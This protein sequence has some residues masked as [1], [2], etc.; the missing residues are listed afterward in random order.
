MKLCTVV[1]LL[2]AVSCKGE[3]SQPAGQGGE[4]PASQS[5]DLPEVLY[6]TGDARPKALDYHDGML[7]WGQS[8]PEEGLKIMMAKA[9]GTSKPREIGEAS[10]FDI[11]LR[12]I[13]ASDTHVFWQNAGKI[14]S[15]NIEDGGTEQHE[16]GVSAGGPTLATDAG[17]AV[18]ASPSCLHVAVLNVETGE[19]I[20]EEVPGEYY[21]GTTS[22]AFFDDAVY[23][24][25]GRRIIRFDP[26]LAEV[27]TLWLDEDF[28]GTMRS[29]FPF[30]GNVYVADGSTRRAT[31]Y[32]IDSETG[33]L[34]ISIETLDGQSIFHPDDARGM[35]FLKQWTSSRSPNQ[36]YD[37]SSKT[38]TDLP[39]ETHLGGNLVGDSNFLYWASD[40]L[41]DPDAIKG[42]Y[43]QRKDPSSR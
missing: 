13:S 4:E 33:A 2:L 25:N 31:L 36:M 28:Q 3:S 23:C 38:L 1:S 37:F 21:G 29:I 26:S 9:D 43:R 5:T 7:Y 34:E 42:I 11:S 35:V 39:G 17:F 40:E 8:T 41:L 20:R 27:E 19:V 18:A 12:L 14:V 10:G 32:R 6:D 22:L 30:G 24:A 15:Y 16:P